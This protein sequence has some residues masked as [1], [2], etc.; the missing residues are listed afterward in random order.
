MCFDNETY[1]KNLS[2]TIMTSFSPS[3]IKNKVSV[4]TSASTFLTLSNKE[5]FPWKSYIVEC[6]WVNKTW[7][8]KF[9]SVFFFT[10]LRYT[11]SHLF[12]LLYSRLVHPTQKEVNV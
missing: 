3:Q 7:E 12:P 6:E 2:E 1:N 10:N 5:K 4:S 9:L 11:F 8:M